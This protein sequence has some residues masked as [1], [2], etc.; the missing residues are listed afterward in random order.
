M[1]DDFITN[2]IQSEVIQAKESG[3]ESTVGGAISL[4]SRDNL[5]RRIDHGLDTSETLG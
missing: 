3:F 4:E 2:Q 5:F 1:E